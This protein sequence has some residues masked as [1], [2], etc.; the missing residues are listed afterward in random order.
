[1]IDTEHDL[2]AFVNDHR[3][4]IMIKALIE[5]GRQ[6][7]FNSDD[8]WGAYRYDEKCVDFNAYRPETEPYISVWAYGV[9]LLEDSTMQINSNLEAFVG[10]VY[11]EE[12]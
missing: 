1:M 5:F 12:K 11:L 3:L 4:D 8:V 7:I 9:E 10:R 6:Q 2:L